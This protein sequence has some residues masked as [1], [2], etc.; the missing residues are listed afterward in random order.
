MVGCCGTGV[1][2]VGL[3]VTVASAEGAATGV[4]LIPS[5]VYTAC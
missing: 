4:T 1:G 5:G 3:G 2:A